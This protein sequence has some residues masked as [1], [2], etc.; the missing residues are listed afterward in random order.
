M[1]LL[2]TT[3][4]AVGPR[5]IALPP[6]ETVA[7]TRAIE[8]WRAS[9]A[10]RMLHVTYEVDSIRGKPETAAAECDS[11][12]VAIAIAD[13]DSIRLARDDHTARLLTAVPIAAL[14]AVAVIWGLSGAE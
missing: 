12:Q 7:P 11:C 14:T 2:T 3:A 4:C 5:R 13:I 1:A 6:A 9:K 10:A 8:V